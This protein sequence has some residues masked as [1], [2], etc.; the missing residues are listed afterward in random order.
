MG[1]MVTHKPRGVTVKEFFEERFNYD[2]NGRY[3]RVVD[4]AVVNL[5]TA[6][7]ACE[8]G[9]HDGEKGIY[10]V[11]CLL[12]YYPNDYYNFGYKVMDETMGPFMYECPERILRLLTPTDNEYALRWREKCWERLRSR[13]NKPKLKKGLLI[14]FAQPI[15][16]TNGAEEKVFRV[17]NPRRLLFE[18]SHGR[19]YKLSRNTLRNMEWVAV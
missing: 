14:E 18:G 9:Y 2:E 7:L 12:S 17:V 5:R 10:G 19:L 11:V 3:F 13:Q 1:W 6:Y 15:T 16:F 8:F 4:C